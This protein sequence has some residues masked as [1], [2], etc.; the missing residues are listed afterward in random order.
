MLAVRIRVFA[1][2]ALLVGWTLLSAIRTVILPRG[3]Q[4]VISGVVFLSIRLPFRWLA[5]ESKSFDVRDRVMALFAPVAL[6]ALPGV[7]LA[8]ITTG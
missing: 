2:G 5:N 6:V 4:S 1:A 3:A 7:W 8:L